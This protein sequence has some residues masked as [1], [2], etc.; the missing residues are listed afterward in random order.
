MP[1]IVCDAAGCD[2][3]LP[4]GKRRYCGSTCQ[5]RMAKRRA[6]AK[7]RAERGG[8]QHDPRIQPAEVHK[9]ANGTAVTK[10]NSQDGRGSARR[11]Q[12]YDQFRAEGWP[13]MLDSGA[14]TVTDVAEQF[15]CRESDVSRWMAAY[16]EDQKTERDQEAWER[17]PTVEEC[18]EDFG[19]FCRRYWPD[20]EITGFH[21]EWADLISEAIDT[22]GRAL[23]LAA[24]RHG[25]ST[26]LR[27]YCAWRICRNPDINIL[28]VSQSMDLA[29]KSV[30]YVLD[31]LTQNTQLVEE[32]LG[33]GREFRPP[34]RSNMSWTAEE[35]TVGVRT[36]VAASPTM[37]AIGKGGSIL[38]RDA[39][40]VIVDDLQEHKHIRSPGMRQ[41][42]V[43]WFFTDLMSRKLPKTGIAVIGSRQHLED[44]YSEIM[45]RGNEWTIKTYPVHDPGCTISEDDHDAHTDCMLWEGQYPYWYMQEQRQQQGEAYFQRN[46]MQRP[47]DDA[48]ILVSAADL[49]RCKDA[50][51][52]VGDIPSGCTLIAGID[53]ADAKPVA[54]V[55]WGYDGERRHV[56][57]IME[58]EPGVRGGRKILR[59][60]RDQYGCNKFV[61]E[62]NMASSWWQ[63]TEIREIL[64]QGISLDPHYSSASNKWH[65]ATGVVAMFSHMRRD[66][67]TITFPWGDRA[68]QQKM[69]RFLKTL[70]IF[71]PDYAGHKHADDDLPMAA[72]FPQPVMDRW[73]QQFVERAQ[74][75][76][77][78]TAYPWST[79][80]PSVRANNR[81]VEVVA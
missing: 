29:K 42:D 30:G 53:P 57:D 21:M 43:E 63:D 11:G 76:F 72:W 16:R 54:A 13:H 44:I 55:L 12:R 71:D 4:K 18:L 32:V 49:D 52:R 27:K 6:R 70:L 61:L 51:R 5:N 75:D 73:G 67:P 46:M 3:P 33:P 23:L 19:A 64:A 1:K 28:W 80:Y 58:A 35:F 45:K 81:R 56:I 2:K 79:A 47:K 34:S 78:Q 17:D 77:P 7:A 20:D 59:S 36:K 26:M 14:M 62:K 48:T 25:K 31:I 10:A 74:I 39:D 24:Q 38:S 69:E 37:V 22:G 40:V 66:P 50:T 68:S 60:W 8:W 9:P 41:K 15:E 65:E